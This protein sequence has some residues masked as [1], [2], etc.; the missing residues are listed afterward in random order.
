[1]GL[2]VAAQIG[3]AAVGAFSQM[4]Y[5]K[6]ALSVTR[7]MQQL[8]ANMAMEAAAKTRESFEEALTEQQAD[9]R[10]VGEQKKSDAARVADR[11]AAELVAIMAEKGQLSTTSFLRQAQQLN[12]FAAIDDIRID[13]DVKKR[14][15]SL[16]ADKE[17]VVEDQRKVYNSSQLALYSA[18]VNYKLGRAF[19]KQQAFMQIG[20]AAA[21]ALVGQHRH[22][23]QLAAAKNTT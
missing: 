16:Q 8:E 12:Y 1:M 10:E 21:S 2:P 6:R 17:Q 7:N 14:I 20:N 15:E 19:A 22:N 3:L 18:N 5:Q 4:Q 13:T 23:Q 9:T 11:E